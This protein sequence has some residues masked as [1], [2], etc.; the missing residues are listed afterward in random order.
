MNL[1]SYS[2]S[3]SLSLSFFFFEMKVIVTLRITCILNSVGSW[4][5]FFFWLCLVSRNNWLNLVFKLLL[6]RVGY[7][8]SIFHCIYYFIQPVTSKLVFTN[9]TDIW[10]LF[11]YIDCN[12]VMAT[13][14]KLTQGELTK[15]EILRETRKWSRNWLK[16][17]WACVKKKVYI[18]YKS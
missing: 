3:L 1:W 4:V 11:C 15:M 14:T 18:C 9:N 16:T 2:H 12:C 8:R 13:S 7:D 10:Y 17:G 5:F 6:R